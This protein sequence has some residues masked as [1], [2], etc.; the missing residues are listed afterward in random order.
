MDCVD[1]PEFRWAISAEAVAFFIF[2][3]P[4]SLL[5]KVFA[6]TPGYLHIETW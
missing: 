2:I 3:H 6:I 5:A 1:R 4:I